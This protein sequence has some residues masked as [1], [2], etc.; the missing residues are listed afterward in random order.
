MKVYVDRWFTA[1][2]MKLDRI[3]G[4][5]GLYALWIETSF[6]IHTTLEELRAFADELTVLVEDAE[7][8]AV[9]ADLGLN[10]SDEAAP[11]GDA[12]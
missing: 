6:T 12:A 8:K 11:D 7:T 3:L 9:A 2:G 10:E 5:P 1:N 4:H